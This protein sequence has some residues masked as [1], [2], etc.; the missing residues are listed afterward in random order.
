MTDV[1]TPRNRSAALFLLHTNIR[2]L[3]KYLVNLNHDFLQTLTHLPD[4]ICFSE[5]K[6]KDSF[7]VNIDLVGY[8]PLIH[9]DSKINVGGVSAL[10][11]V[12][13]VFT[14]LL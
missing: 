3:Q 10:I 12:D 11:S 13:L 9:A 6:L 5:I 8:E 14:E 7:L 1:F 2:S 4:I